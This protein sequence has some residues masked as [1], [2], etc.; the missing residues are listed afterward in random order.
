MGGV[1]Y[2]E[3]AYWIIDLMEFIGRSLARENYFSLLIILA[4]ILILYNEL[5]E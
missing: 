2:K 3:R 1:F 5:V 4:L